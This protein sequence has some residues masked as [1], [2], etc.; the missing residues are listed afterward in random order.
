MKNF[1]KTIS[2][3]MPAY[4]EEANIEETVTLCA[5]S[6]KALQ[7]NGEIVVTN[8]GSR[9]RTKD[10]LD[11]LKTKIPNLVVVEHKEN[12]GYGSGLSDAITAAKGLILE[13]GGIFGLDLAKTVREKTID[14]S[15]IRIFIKDRNEA[16]NN[17]DFKRADDIRKK[18]ASEGVIIEDTKDGAVWLNKI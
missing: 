5:E 11:A 7:I 3:V 6:L 18:L 1:N 2:V 9:D 16:R 14:E 17:K 12:Q 10:I 13:L 8:D 15:E 4:N